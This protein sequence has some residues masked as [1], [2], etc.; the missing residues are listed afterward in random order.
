MI[1]ALRD[2][3]VIRAEYLPVTGL[4]EYIAYNKTFDIVKIGED[5]PEYDCVVNKDNDGNIRVR[6]VKLHIGERGYHMG[7]NVNCIYAKM[8]PYT[9]VIKCTNKKLPKANILARMAGNGDN[10]VLALM[11][12][13]SECK[14]Q[15]EVLRPPKPQI[16]KCVDGKKMFVQPKQSNVYDCMKC[17]H[18]MIGDKDGLRCEKCNGHIIPI[19][20]ATIDDIKKY[21][22]KGKNK[23]M[24]FNKD[25]LINSN[26]IIGKALNN[27]KPSLEGSPSLRQFS[28]VANCV[29]REVEK[30]CNNSE[31]S[32]KTTK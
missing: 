3:L 24:E 5:I 18:R 15:E 23:S 22:E 13:H 25:F 12:P 21:K 8:E 2:C 11:H 27:Y 9:H 32:K 10:C 31:I 29:L 7:R 1:Q 16:T 6:F 26:E 28:D 30:V 17:G 19:R 14:L 4:I 20:K